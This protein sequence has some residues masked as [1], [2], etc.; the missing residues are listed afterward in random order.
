MIKLIDILREIKVNK[1]YRVWNLTK[2]IPNFNPEDIK[3]GDEII[4]PA[5]NMAH[6]GE[7]VRGKIWDINDDEVSPRLGKRLHYSTEK[8][9][10]YLGYFDE[11][12][13]INNKNKSKEN[14]QENK[15]LNIP[16]G[17]YEGTISSYDVTIKNPKITFRCITGYKNMNPIPCT[18]FIEN[19]E[20][21]V[22]SKGGIIFSSEKAQSNF[23]EKYGKGGDGMMKFPGMKKYL[24]K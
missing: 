15:S 22:C 2:Y 17:E 10:N 3:V 18:V 13:K 20:A 24:N 6:E 5:F 4:L 8:N 19:G 23:R 21:I 7:N 9:G 12:E 1:P 11:L 14:L 16:N